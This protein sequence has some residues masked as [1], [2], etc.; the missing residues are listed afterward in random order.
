MEDLKYKETGLGL[1]GF[2]ASLFVGILSVDEYFLNKILNPKH[3][4]IAVNVLVFIALATLFLGVLFVYLD[5]KGLK[6][7]SKQDEVYKNSLMATNEFEAFDELLEYYFG[8]SRIDLN[9]IKQFHIKNSNT[10]W[11]LKKK[12]KL[13]FRTVVDYM[14]FII[15]YPVNKETKIMLERDEIYGAEFTADNL[16]KE[17]EEPE[18]HYIACIAGKDLYSKAYSIGVLKSIVRER[19]GRK[20]IYT[21]P[22]SDQ[23][24][25]LAKKYGFEKAN[26]L[27]PE[28]DKKRIYKFVY[29]EKK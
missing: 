26:Q 12:K 17:E 27:H 13:K 6:L 7:F 20:P 15:I 14:G 24:L 16:C 8:S 10:T 9:Q 28:Q 4:V 19:L 11:L 22:V 5:Y 25:R 2:G 21:Y 29:Q 23:G 18:G 3:H 1:I